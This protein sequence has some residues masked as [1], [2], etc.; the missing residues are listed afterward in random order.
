MPAEP[1]EA[2]SPVAATPCPPGVATL[3]A[4]Y[5][6]FQDVTAGVEAPRPSTSTRTSSARPARSFEA[7]LGSTFQ[8]PGAGR[9]D[10]ARLPREELPRRQPAQ[11]QLDPGGQRRVLRRRTPGSSRSSTTWSSRTSRRPRVTAS[12][13]PSSSGF[14][15]QA[16]ITGAAL[17]DLAAVRRRRQVRRLRQLGRGAELRRRRAR[18]PDREDRRRGG[19]AVDHR[20]R[21]RC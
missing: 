3:G 16:G 21:R 7:A 6:A 1:G 14:A 4:G 8:E 18:H 2:R 11:R 20:L 10:Q 5:P 15:E 17:D 9:Q 19:R 13:T 12:P